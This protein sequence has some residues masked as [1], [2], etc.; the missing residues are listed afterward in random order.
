MQHPKHGMKRYALAVDLG[1]TNVRVAMISSH[2][3]II[4]KIKEKT[5]KKGATGM[6]ITRQIIRMIYAVLAAQEHKHE[7]PMGIGISSFGPLSIDAG[8][9]RH[10]PNTT[11]P[12]IPLVRPL[13]KEFALP[14]RLLNDC[15][16]AVLGEQTFGAGRGVDNLLYITISTGIGAGA[17]VNGTLLL[18]RGGNAAEVGHF[19]VDTKYNLP[20]TCKKGV[21]HWEGYASG[22]NI[23]RFFWCCAGMK[24]K[25]FK[26]QFQTAKDIFAAGRARNPA[27]RDFLDE[28]SKMNARGISNII[29]AYDPQLITLGGSVVLENR[30]IILD[31]IKRYTDNFLKMPTIKITP[32]GED[33]TLLGAAAAIDAV[34]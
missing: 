6:V 23:P 11:F 13:Q 31:G 9:P 29:A 8:G 14:V 12:F 33:I 10:G 15:N 18:G 30:K 24:T 5:E 7:R 26:K 2:G 21:G 25:R 19:I 22:R 17:I 28:L 34:A 4:Y 3:D 20:C 1:A 27:V 32:L 16:A